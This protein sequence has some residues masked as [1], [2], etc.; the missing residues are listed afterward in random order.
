M[1][2][3][4]GANRVV[5]GSR[6]HHPC[7][8]GDGPTVASRAWR[9]AVVQAA[10]RAL[11]APVEEPTLFEVAGGSDISSVVSYPRRLANP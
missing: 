5:R 11:A 4:V 1:A 6:F 7:G 9:R 3:S 8:L 10:L 2:L